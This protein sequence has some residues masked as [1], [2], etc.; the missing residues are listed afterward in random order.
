MDRV[1][2]FDYCALALLVVLLLTLVLRKMT[3][4][5]VGRQFIFL[6]GATVIACAADTW[7]NALDMVGEG[8]IAQK[9]LA[10]TI[11]YL[12]HTGTM[13]VFLTY[14]I[15]LTDTWHIVKKHV[16][17]MVML[18]LPMVFMC[19]VLVVNT[20]TPVIF[21]LDE[22]DIYARGPYH[23]LSYVVAG[24]YVLYSVIYSIKYYRTLGAMRFSAIM[25]MYI[26][27]LVA[28]LI[29]F[30]YPQVPVEMYCNALALLFLSMMVLRPED[31]IDSESKLY[32]LKA[33]ISNIRSTLDN[34]KRIEIIQ[35]NVTNYKSLREML[36]YEGMSDVM[37]RIAKLIFAIDLKWKLDSE[38]YN[39]GNGKIRLVVNEK[40]FGKAEGVA[41]EINELL[42]KDVTLKYGKI[43]VIA[44]VCL[45]RMPE[46]V[47]DLESLMAFGDDLTTYPYTGKVLYAS[48]IFK[49]RYYDIMRDIDVIIEHALAEKKFEVYYQPIYSVKETRFASAEALLRLKDEKYGF[50]SPEIFIPASEKSGAIHRVGDYVLEEVCRFISSEVYSKLGLDYIEVNLSV[51]QCMSNELADKV[52]DTLKRFNVSPSQ[53]N[54]EVTETAVEFSHSTLMENLSKLTDAGIMLSLDDFGTGYSNMRRIALLPLSIVKLDRSF[55]NAEDTPNM[56]I[57]LEDTIRMIKNMQMKIVV[58]GIET[59]ELVKMYS[60]LQCEYIQGYYYSKPIPKDDFTEFIMNS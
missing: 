11:Y 13:A 35:V 25:S 40:K 9:Y 5:H 50:I 2:Y 36:G 33:Y 23:Y 10:N 54:L 47:N 59:E 14:I 52:L 16:G 18:I 41:Q 42:K 31:N 38:I 6:V 58:E 55:T 20:I 19:V 56:H 49:K 7:A 22:A 3:R 26:L 48:E 57:V 34:Q 53:I 46:D 45:A 44:N 4:G 17:L 30:Y 8:E 12:F 15:T 39:L 29:Q 43:S 24:I 37:T 60:D 51:A 28:V 1:I 21:Y 32:K 27:T